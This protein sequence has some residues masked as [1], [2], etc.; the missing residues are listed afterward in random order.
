MPKW[1]KCTIAKGMFSDEVTVIIRTRSGENVSV[2]VPKYA[3]ET[4]DRVKVRVVER[5]GHT[6]ALLPDEHQSVVDIESTELVPA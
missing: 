4:N 6:V 2:F 3:T 5:A 1:L